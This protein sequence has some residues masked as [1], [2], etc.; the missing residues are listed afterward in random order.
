M[1]NTGSQAMQDEFVLSLIGKHTFIDIGCY[2]PMRFNNTYLLEQKGWTGIAIDII[3]YSGL[4]RI[5]ST[6]FICADSLE[7]DYTDMLKDFP[8]VIDYL[9][10]DVEGNGD[11][12]K[13]LERVF[14]S[15]H[16]FRVITIEHDVYK[17]PE[18]IEAGPQREFL[19]ANGYHL[20]CKN[21]KA[22]TRPFEDWWVNPKY[23]QDYERYQCDRLH[24]SEIMK[25]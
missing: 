20:V 3:D 4:W 10:I 25:L 1:G 8:G 16:E 24:C 23:V 12:F 19:A 15:G 7:C 5:R 17:I 11:R 22:D 9:S 2:W 13:T 6:P 14:E 21:V 18:H